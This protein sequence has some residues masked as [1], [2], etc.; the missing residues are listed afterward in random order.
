MSVE[1]AH[2]FDDLVAHVPHLLV[3]LAEEDDSPRGLHV[4]GG[5]AVA[6]G[7]VDEGPDALLGHSGR[8]FVGEGV[9][10]LAVQDG[11]FEGDGAGGVGAW[12]WHR[13][14]GGVGLGLGL[15]GERV[16]G[17]GLWGAGGK[18]GEELVH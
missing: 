9:D 7:E 8:E 10:G 18:F 16:F 15:V 6:D 4:E 13:G 11:V 1:Q 5:R 3:L 2:R 17:D 12:G 14:G